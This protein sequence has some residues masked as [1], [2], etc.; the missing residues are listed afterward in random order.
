MSKLQFIDQPLQVAVR[1]TQ[2][3]F[4]ANLK[5]ENPKTLTYAYLIEIEK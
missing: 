4:H 2:G 1:Y 3:G 5:K